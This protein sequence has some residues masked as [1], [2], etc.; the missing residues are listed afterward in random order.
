MRDLLN[1]IRVIWQLRVD[2][3]SISLRYALVPI[4]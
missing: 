1:A 2:S 3:L 4:H